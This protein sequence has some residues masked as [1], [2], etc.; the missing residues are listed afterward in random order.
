MDDYIVVDS[1]TMQC[2]YGCIEATFLNSEDNGFV[3]EDKNAILDNNVTI[4][5]FLFCSLHKKACR[6]KTSKQKWQKSANCGT[7]EGKYITTKSVLA[8]KEGGLVS[9]VNAGQD[10]VIEKAGMLKFLDPE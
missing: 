9:I 8:C 3:I 7:D 6:F 4:G 10:C 1:A 2:K 5:D